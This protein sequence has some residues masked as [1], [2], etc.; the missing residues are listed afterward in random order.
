[1]GNPQHLEWLLEGVEAWNA[2]RQYDHFTPDLSGFDIYS[3]FKQAGKLTIRGRIPLKNINFSNADIRG[4]NLS[5]ADLQNANLRD[6][7]LGPYLGGNEDVDNSAQLSAPNPTN[8]K[9]NVITRE[10][11]VTNRET[12]VL[13]SASLLQQIADYRFKIY[14]DN[15]LACDHPEHRDGLLAFLD[16]LSA[17]IELLLQQVPAAGAEATEEQAEQ[18]ASWFDRFTGAALPEWQKYLA[19]EAL[20]KASAPGGIILGFGAL[21]ALVT[22]VNPLGFGAG[23]MVGKWITGEMKSGQAADKLSEMFE[24]DAPEN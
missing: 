4:A 7:D 14:S 10:K 13:T 12:L 5:K 23:A 15:Q 19:P 11:L 18:A 6:A 20:G 24:T 3:E 1:M 16:Q 9:Q 22:G 17:D 21:G 2:R 8:G